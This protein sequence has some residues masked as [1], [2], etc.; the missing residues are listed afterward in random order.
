M[1]NG[2]SENRDDGWVSCTACKLGV[3]GVGSVQGAGGGSPGLSGR[4]VVLRSIEP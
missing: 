2:A 4:G 3:D 1:Q